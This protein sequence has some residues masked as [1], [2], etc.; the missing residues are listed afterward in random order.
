MAND[1]PGASDID[2]IVSR[3]ESELQGKFQHAPLEIAHF[4]GFHLTPFRRGAVPLDLFLEND[5]LRVFGGGGTRIDVEFAV[6]SASGRR[7]R[8]TEFITN[9]GLFGAVRPW[10]IGKRFGGRVIVPESDRQLEN[11]MTRRVLLKQRV[12]PPW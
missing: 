6:G 11:L 12:W 7:D 9:V 4:Y 10:S 2:L 3:V 8:A 5:W 1:A